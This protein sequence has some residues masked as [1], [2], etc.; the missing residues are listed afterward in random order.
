MRLT[1]RILPFLEKVNIDALLLKWFPNWEQNARNTVANEYAKRKGEV[2]IFW[3]DQPDLRFSQTLVNIG[4]LP[5]SPGLWYYDEEEEILIEQGHDAA[6]VIFW[7]QNFDKDMNRLPKTV[8]RPIA[9][10][11]SE[12]IQAVLSGEYTKNELYLKTFNEELTR[13]KNAE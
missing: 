13:R 5:N 4:L 3:E 6:E 7:G 1:E 9:N 11:T 8:W 10:M 2:Q 12:H